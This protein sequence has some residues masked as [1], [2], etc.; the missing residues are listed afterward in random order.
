MKGDN[1]IDEKEM[2][3]SEALYSFMGWL[4]TRDEPVTFSGVHDAG[5]AACLVDEFCKK[6]NLSPPSD[7]WVGKIL[8]GM[9]SSD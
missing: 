5:V 9:N 3:A 8:N 6:Q 1:M 4:T 7:D 2:S